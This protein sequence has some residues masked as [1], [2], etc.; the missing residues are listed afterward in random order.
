MKTNIGLRRELDFLKSATRSNGLDP[1]KMV[2]K[3]LAMGIKQELKLFKDACRVKGLDPDKMITS[4]MRKKKPKPEQR[5]Q[6][7][8]PEQMSEK[9]SKILAKIDS[10]SPKALGEGLKDYSKKAR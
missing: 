6:V 7:S 2:K 8:K 5:K 1:S 4:E 10:Y 3:T 9:A